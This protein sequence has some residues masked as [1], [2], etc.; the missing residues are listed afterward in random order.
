[1]IGSLG[2]VS[3][4]ACSRWNLSPYKFR[5]A[6]VGYIVQIT[7]GIVLAAGAVS[8]L[9]SRKSL[10]ETI[11][12]YQILR[13][14]L[15]KPFAVGL[16]VIEALLAVCHITGLLVVAAAGV[17][18]VLFVAFIVAIGMNLRRGSLI[19]CH[20]FGE[21][22]A[23]SV[24]SIARPAILCVGEMLIMY[25]VVSSRAGWSDPPPISNVRELLVFWI[26]AV[27]CLV[28]VS[29]WALWTPHLLE[30]VRSNR[31]LLSGG[32]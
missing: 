30:L 27:V 15:I 29:N 32:Q 24:V 20:C 13:A 16:V 17:G 18:A 6:E 9:V 5:V 12:D 10:V 3:I 8:K 4:L 19:D 22:E 23:V 14:S 2:G 11:D 7:V 21:G 31:E 26:P 28:L 25:K 1:M